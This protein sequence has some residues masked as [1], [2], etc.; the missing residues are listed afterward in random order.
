MGQ[1]FPLESFDDDTPVVDPAE[2]AYQE[3]FTAGEA[4]GRARA[5]ED[6]TTLKA[7]LVHAI[8]DLEFTNSEARG[9]MTRAMAPL[10][11]ALVE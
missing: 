8:A 3:G 10:M 5:E 2:A 11:Q 4:A 9:E 7:A 6:Q 1:V